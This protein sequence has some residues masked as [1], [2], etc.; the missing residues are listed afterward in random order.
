MNHIFS[1]E[2]RIRRSEY[3]ITFLLMFGL[4]FVSQ[5]V[6]IALMEA[7]G[8]SGVLIIYIL[9]SLLITWIMYAQGAKR[10]HDLG[11]NGWWQLIPFFFLWLIFQD[12]Q[13]GQNKYGANPKELA[14]SGSQSGGTSQYGN[15]GEYQGTYDGGHNKPTNIEQRKNDGEYKDGTLYD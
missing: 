12:G 11:K 6:M 2:G 8:G 9:L 10:C 3:G 5:T 1:F 7:G 4:S 13:S 14:M 15:P